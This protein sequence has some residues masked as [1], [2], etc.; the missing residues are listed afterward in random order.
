MQHK[1][2]SPPISYVMFYSNFT[3]AEAAYSRARMPLVSQHLTVSSVC[4]VP[5]LRCL[6]TA[7]VYT[8]FL[9]NR[10]T[11]LEV[12]LGGHTTWRS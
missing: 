9:E 5:G 11:G 2:L 1:I 12:E 6:L 7:Y 3:L 10:Q 4:H 8:K